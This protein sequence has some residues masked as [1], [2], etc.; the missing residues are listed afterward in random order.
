MERFHR[1][2]GLRL[3]TESWRI[4]LHTHYNLIINNKQVKENEVFTLSARNSQ[5]HHLYSA[6]QYDVSYFNDG[7]SSY[8]F[9]L[10]V[11]ARGGLLNSNTHILNLDS[12]KECTA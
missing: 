8:I 12:S 1:S 10:I 7:I 9:S 5:L 11:K 6:L 4:D 2:S 3:R